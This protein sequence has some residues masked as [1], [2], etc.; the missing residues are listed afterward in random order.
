MNLILRG[1]SLASRIRFKMGVKT[2]QGGLD[3]VLILIKV[4]ISYLNAAKS[5]GSKV[6]LSLAHL[7][8]A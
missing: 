8:L 7:G 5:Q 2:T 3:N 1:L 4:V 6:G